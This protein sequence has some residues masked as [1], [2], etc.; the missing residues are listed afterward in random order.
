MQPSRRHCLYASLAMLAFLL[1]AP[2]TRAESLTITSSPS[3]ATVE[4]DGVVVGT[5]PCTVKYPGGYFHKT[6]TVFGQRL[7]HS[8]TIRVYK[9]GYTSQDLKLTNGPF[10]WV[11]LNGQNHGRYWLVTTNHIQATLKPV[12]TVFT[13]AVRTTTAHGRE[14]ELRPELPTEQIVERARP[15]VVKLR[16]ADGW[17]TG[18]LIT[19]TGVIATN[20][21][22]VEGQTSVV[23][24]FSNGAELLGMVVY[25][26]PEP[27]PDLALVK[28]DVTDFPYLPLADI[29]NVHVGQTVVA[30][31]NP[32]K[33][34]PNSVTRGIV[35][36]IGSKHEYGDG[37]WIQTDAA[38]NPG[39]SGGPLVDAYGEVVGITTQK[40]FISSD[41]RPLQSIA[42]ALSSKDLLAA[43]RRFYPEEVSVAQPTSAPASGV[44]TLTIS[45]DT[46]GAEIY[47]D[48]KFV[49]QTP[50]T[51]QLSSSSHHVEVRT[52]G[53]KNWARDLE[54]LQDSQLTLHPVLDASP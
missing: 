38:I 36:A 44:G 42:F 24:V 49:G 51:I 21:H 6:H 3:G 34:L 13:G 31:G 12:S 52:P 25:V 2:R 28:T 27:Q 41:D 16:N 17:G 46:A 8:L 37:T 32:D 53:K 19:D 22:V 43:L 39:N 48:G 20:R 1:L 23:V 50:S 9:D 35:S 54:V 26:S 10:E 14:V 18:F 4:I 29:K 15:A 7:E 47:I 11:A 45:C 40:Q 33:G 5:T 30:V